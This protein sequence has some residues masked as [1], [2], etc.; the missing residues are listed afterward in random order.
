[1]SGNDTV[2]IKIKRDIRSAGMTVFEDIRSKGLKG[3]RYIGQVPQKLC[4]FFPFNLFTFVPLC[5]SA[6]FF[7]LTL[8][9]N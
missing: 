3:L 1:M 9:P 2:C 6:I 4:A 7:F 8:T 5:R